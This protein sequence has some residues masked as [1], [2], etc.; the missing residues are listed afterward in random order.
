MANPRIPRV[1]IG[2]RIAIPG[3]Q[4]AHPATPAVQVQR[5][6]APVAPPGVV[7]ALP[8]DPE[9]N[10]PLAAPAGLPES[11]EADWCVR[12]IA[13]HARLRAKSFY[14][15]GRLLDRL[16][17]LKGVYGAANIKELRIKAG[18]EMSHMTANKYLQ[19]ARAFPRDLALRTGIEKCYA[20]IVYSKVVG[21]K[22]ED[23]ASL[24]TANQRIQGGP[25]G[26]T[27]QSASATA[28]YAAIKSIKDARK[29]STEPTQLVAA[30]KATADS[31]EKLIRLLGF[32]GAITDVIHKRGEARIA[33]YVSLETAAQ[34]E[35]LVPKA[36]GRAVP[37][38]AKTSPDVAAVL[39]AAGWSG[40]A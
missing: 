8:A 2:P 21:K 1:G 12:A 19:I 18:L 33:I 7:A 5:P 38:F 39:K 11:K 16:M 3:V 10:I 15:T 31:V 25:R 20:L 23:A 36:L 37:R 27:A 26:L 35:T 17:A 40:R 13:A 6:R 4:P 34:L 14:D 22:P 30:R 32:K 29:Q 28:I 9:P 24:L